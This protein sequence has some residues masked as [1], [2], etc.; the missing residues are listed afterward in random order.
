MVVFFADVGRRR[1]VSWLAW[2][3]LGSTLGLLGWARWRRRQSAALTKPGQ[4]TGTVL[5]LGEPEEIR[6]VLRQGSSRSFANQ[7]LVAAVIPER[8]LTGRPQRLGRIPVLGSS[9][10]IVEIA[11]ATGAVTLILAGAEAAQQAATLRSALADSDTELLV[12]STKVSL[13]GLLGQ[14]MLSCQT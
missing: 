10:K 11:R 6:A 8:Y 12:A 13:T 2:L 4:Q 7:Y 5:L 14:R 3:L 1:A 9:E